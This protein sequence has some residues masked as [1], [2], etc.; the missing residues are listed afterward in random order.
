MKDLTMFD[1]VWYTTIVGWVLYY[2]G[3]IE[4]SG[5]KLLVPMFVSFVISVITTLIDA[6]FFEGRN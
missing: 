4:V 2:W 3:V 5:I 1:I 6:V